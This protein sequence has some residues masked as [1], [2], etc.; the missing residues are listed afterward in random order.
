MLSP[1]EKSA[2]LLSSKSWFKDTLA[3]N[4]IKNTVKLVNPKEFN[5]NP[6]LI[7]YLSKYL[8]GDT[9][10]ESLAKALIYPRVLGSSI[11]T[12]FG[13]NLQTYITQALSAFGSITPGIDIEY[14][15]SVD[16]R[17]KYCQLKAGPNT[18]NK[19][20]V[21]TIDDHFKDIKNLARTNALSLQMNDL[22]VGVLYGE[23]DDI[24]SH[25]KS[26]RD[27]KHYE[28]LVGEELWYRITGDRNFYDDLQSAIAE[29]ATELGGKK[30]L[31]ET[32]KDL[33]NHPDII[34][35]SESLK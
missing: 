28:V 30:E 3:I 12:S 7:G 33:A 35:L 14:T 25:Y 17:K 6:F 29:V 16:G 21:K 8:N 24:S 19:D 31:E 13:Q 27:E 5:V 2:I 15:D 23:N 11:T 9:S 32:I 20:D 26:L 10:P 4:H 1:E 18:I 34:E 22:I